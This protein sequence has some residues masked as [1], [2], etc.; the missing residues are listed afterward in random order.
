MSNPDRRETQ[1]ID[2]SVLLENGLTFNV[3]ELSKED[4]RNYWQKGHALPFAVDMSGALMLSDEPHAKL[5]KLPQEEVILK[6][7]FD[8][9]GR[10]IL[11]VN[12]LPF[13]QSYSN[14]NRQT[15]SIIIRRKIFDF[16]NRNE[17]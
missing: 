7:D 17:V 1:R 10:A 14:L 12:E 16:L 9:T 2:F 13:P 5:N 3:S 6:G 4:L 15:L 11:E 8:K